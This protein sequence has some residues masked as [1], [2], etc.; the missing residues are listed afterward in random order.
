MNPEVIARRIIEK[1]D[2]FEITQAEALSM[3]CDE[4]IHTLAAKHIN[5][6]I[7]V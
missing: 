6:Y 3:T 7:R 2:T 5:G 4:C 1:R